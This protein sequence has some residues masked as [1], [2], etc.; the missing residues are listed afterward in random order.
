MLCLRKT[1]L[2]GLMTLPADVVFALTPEPGPPVGQAA[3]KPR[4]HITSATDRL[5]AEQERF[6]DFR[7]EAFKQ[8]LLKAWQQ[9]LERSRPHPRNSH[10]DPRS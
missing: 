10:D 1:V 6:G 4:P 9:H 7:S 2:I 5:K 8:G 3:G